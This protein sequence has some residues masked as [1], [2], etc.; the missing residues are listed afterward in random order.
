VWPPLDAF[1]YNMMT[2]NVVIGFSIP[3]LTAAAYYPSGSW[4]LATAVSATVCVA[5]AIVYAFLASSMPR[6][7]GEYYFQARILSTGVASV[8]CFTALVFGGALWMAIT[9]WYASRLAVAPLLV[10]LSVALD[11]PALMSAAVWVQHPWGV[12]LLSV[13]VIAWAAAANILGLR[14]YAFM[15][16]AFWAVA[17]VLLISVV[18]GL[19]LARDIGDLPIY[20]EATRRAFSEGFTMNSLS[21]FAAV[22]AVAP[23]A[24]F[25]LVYLG[26]STQ[27]SGET[28]RAGELG[29][30]MRVILVSMLVTAALS[31]AIGGLTVERFGARTLGAGAYLFLQAPES[32][33]LPTVP[34]LW[35]CTSGSRASEAFGMITALL[36]NAL[37]WMYVPNSTLAASRVLL[38][39]S[40]DRVLPRWIGALHAT[41][42]APVNAIVSFSALCL[43]ACCVY[44]LTSY[45]RL[46]FSTAALTNILA[47]AVTCAAGALVPFVKREAFREST[48]ARFEFLGVPVIT[49][50]GG[51]FAVFTGVLTWR[52]VTDPALSMGLGSGELIVSS[53]I[54]YAFSLAVYLVFGAFRRSRIGAEIEVFYTETGATTMSTGGR[55]STV[56]VSA[57]T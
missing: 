40:S 3:F 47:F 15:Q 46:L 21:G 44:S 28:R 53:G 20:R 45:W 14:R 48:A 49:V 27:Q 33:P 57:R 11:S 23:L 18:I 17:V 2:I 9:A 25:T 55:P 22:M 54:F 1:L 37:F 34:F 5:E 7:G 12:L 39:M 42:K 56:R 31:A 13:I 4:A 35:F 36:F 26:W 30:Q 43:V 24:S 50:M 52:F 10:A 16:R 19:L 6:S 38:A 41:T 32:M 51:A 8:F 29:V